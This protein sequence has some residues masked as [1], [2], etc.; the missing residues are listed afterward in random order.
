MMSHGMADGIDR[1]MGCRRPMMMSRSAALQALRGQIEWPLRIQD[2]PPQ[3]TS[4]DPRSSGHQVHMAEHL[5]MM[6]ERRK[7]GH[8]PATGVKAPP[9]RLRR[10]PMIKK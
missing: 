3:G 9:R 8:D 7:R 2:G 6:K 5:A 1:H 4:K 10:L